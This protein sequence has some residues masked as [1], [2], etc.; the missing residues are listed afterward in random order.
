MAEPDRSNVVIG[1]FRERP[2]AEQALDELRNK[3]YDDEHL[4]FACPGQEGDSE[5]VSQPGKAT[6]PGKDAEA[7]V[8]G[9]GVIGGA[10]GAAATGLIPGIGPVVA[11][12]AL[13]GI[14]GGAAIGGAAGTFAA[15]MNEMGVDEQVAQTCEEQLRSGRSII[16]VQTEDTAPVREVL[17]RHAVMEIKSAYG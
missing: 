14:L 8:L 7:G 11:V 2:Q 10:V 1:I 13:T 3:G 5:I 17:D 4:G 9:G 16:T 12:G 6:E 15:V